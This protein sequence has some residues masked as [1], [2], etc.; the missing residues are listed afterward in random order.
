MVIGSNGL[1]GPPT[2]FA[3]FSDISFD[4]FV[5]DDEPDDELEVVIETGT[6]TALFQFSDTFPFFFVLYI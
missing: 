2:S 5:I 1:S 4:T 6:S 3:L